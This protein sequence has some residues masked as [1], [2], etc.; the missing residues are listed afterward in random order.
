MLDEIEGS[1]FI[2]AFCKVVNYNAN[3]SKPYHLEKLFKE[4]ASVLAALYDQAETTKN[5][6]QMAQSS[7]SLTKY[8]PF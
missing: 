2:D 4:T 7:S 8:L 5:C 3:A 6:K 1:C